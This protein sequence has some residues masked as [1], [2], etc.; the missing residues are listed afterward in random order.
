MTAS[1]DAARKAGTESIVETLAIRNRRGLHARASAKFVSTVGGYDADVWVAKDGIEVNG[2]SIMGLM[3]L[4]AAPGDEIVVRASGAEAR[5]A[6][7]AL[8]KLVEEKFG[9]D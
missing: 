1:G 2:K 5:N 8:T 7:D 9:E 6:I 3:M 4:A